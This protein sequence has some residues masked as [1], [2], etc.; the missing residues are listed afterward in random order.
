M[1]DGYMVTE[2]VSVIAWLIYMVSMVS[3]CNHML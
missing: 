3:L 1:V 2:F